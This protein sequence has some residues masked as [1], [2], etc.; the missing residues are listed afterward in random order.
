MERGWAPPRLTAHRNTMKPQ[1]SKHTMPDRSRPGS[2]TTALPVAVLQGRSD[3]YAT[4]AQTT[5]PAI[6]LSKSN[7]VIGTWN[8]RTLHAH[9][10]TEELTN[11]LS[12][13]NWDILGLAEV[14]WTGFGET[15]TEEGH[16]IWYSGDETKHQHGV[17]FIVNKDRVK[18][19]INCRPINSRIIS[20]RIAAAPLNITIIQVYA[21]TSDYDDEEIEGFYE[22]L[23][24]TIKEAPK[25]DIIVV[26]GDWNAKVGE[27]AHEHWAGIVGRFGC[28]ET[29]DRGLRLLEF[30][31]SHNLT[32]A[33]TLFP[34]K[35]SRRTT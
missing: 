34:H 3:K 19:V 1:Q 22:D 28:G 35:T 23:D 4:G 20:I 15:T 18:S 25:K 5:P 14:R 10:K 27:D 8:V 26:M 32:L 2:T 16:R 31:G 13:Y 9:G 6:K 24:K 30:A 7:T 21:P 12:H 17:G 11:E 33:N 29:N